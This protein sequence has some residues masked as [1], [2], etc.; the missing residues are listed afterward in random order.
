MLQERRLGAPAYEVVNFAMT[1]QWPA[2]WSLAIS[3]R[4][5][6]STEWSREEYDFLTVEELAS[7]VPDVLIDALGL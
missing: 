5:S 3:A 2:G 1:Y 6:G 4:P 7:T